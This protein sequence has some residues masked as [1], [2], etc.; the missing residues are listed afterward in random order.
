MRVDALA[1]LAWRTGW[2]RSPGARRSRV[3]SAISGRDL[4]Q[5]RGDV[6]VR[7][8]VKAV[9]LHAGVAGSR[10]AAA[11]ARR[12]PAGRDESWCRS[13]PPAARPAGAR[14]PLR[15]A[16]GCAAGAAARAASAR[17]ARPAPRGVTTVGPRE[18]AARRGPRG[19]RRRACARRRSVERS[20]TA[21]DIERGAR[22]RARRRR[23]WRSASLT[24]RAV[25][26]GQARRACRCP[27][28]GRAPPAASRGRRSPVHAELQARRARVQDQRV[29][30]HADRSAHRR[31]ARAAA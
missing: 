6:L 23:S 13:R 8:A 21:S 12:R 10:G 28:S 5:H 1:L 11:P 14:R 19:G 2:R 30:V 7:E 22:R 18:R 4:G 25:L 29:V 3:R 27:R 20:Q 9:A 17:A 26:R 15:S 31:A 24:A 16:P